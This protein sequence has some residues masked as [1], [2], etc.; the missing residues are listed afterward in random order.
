MGDYEFI[1]YDFEDPSLLERYIGLPLLRLVGERVYYRPFLRKIRFENAD[2]V[3]DFGCGAG[4]STRSIL[5]MLG[6]E[7]RV[8]G[9]DTSAFWL[10]H[11]RKRLKGRENVTLEHA[12]IRERG[13]GNGRFDK[14]V[15]IFVLHDIHP[16][17]RPAIVESIVKALKP[18]GQCCVYEP[19]KYT[20]GMAPEEVR[21]IMTKAGLKEIQT[22]TR[23]GKWFQ[24]IYEKGRE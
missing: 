6:D 16:L 15:I 10:D 4:E 13:Q 12:D 14:A 22:R 11:A 8:T 1:E 18:G 17:D 23:E 20:H 5:N 24:G 21:K 7:G 9:I 19:A 2:N 3:L